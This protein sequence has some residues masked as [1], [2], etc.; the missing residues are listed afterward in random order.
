MPVGSPY[1]HFNIISQTLLYLTVFFLLET[2]NYAI[3]KAK[4]CFATITDHCIKRAS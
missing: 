3:I 1:H 2:N 4:Y